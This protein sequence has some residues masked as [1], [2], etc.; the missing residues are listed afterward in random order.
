MVDGRPA[1]RPCKLKKKRCTH[2]AVVESE[3][4]VDSELVNEALPARR[5]HDVQA[6]DGSTDELSSI[7]S[8]L[9]SEKP[10]PK[11]RA[12]RGRPFAPIVPS[13]LPEIGD[14]PSDAMEAASAL[15]VHRVFARELESR[16]QEYDVNFQASQQAHR[17][18]ITSAKAVKR[19]VEN[20]IEA[21]S[22]G[23]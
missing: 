16:L 13:S 6:Q 23:R 10:I 5:R 9:E 22:S 11:K 18:T 4:E 12:K 19:A 7:A 20:W 15:A 21:W 2:R 1:C 3:T 17:A 14:L 8:D